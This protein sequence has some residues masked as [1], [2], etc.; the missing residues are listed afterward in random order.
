M[1]VKPQQN[2]CFIHFARL[3]EIII[4]FLLPT[5]T[6]AGSSRQTQGETSSRFSVIFTSRRGFDHLIDQL[7]A[8]ST[9]NRPVL[10]VIWAVRR[11]LICCWL[12]CVFRERYWPARSRKTLRYD[13]PVVHCD[14]VEPYQIVDTLLFEEI[15]MTAGLLTSLPFLYFL[16]PLSIY[17]CLCVI[18]NYDKHTLI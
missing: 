13:S 18:S 10:V 17:F 5:V 2:S 6:S 14:R 16:L 11:C 3:N 9:A 8:D 4:F 7:L 1:W 15:P 12:V